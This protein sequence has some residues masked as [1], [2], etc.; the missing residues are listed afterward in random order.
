[1]TTKKKTE[2]EMLKLLR[3]RYGAEQGN[4][5]AYAFVEGV[6]ND[7]GFNASRTIDAMAMSLWPSRGLL[8]SAF[9]IKTAR[10]DWLRELRDPSKA[11]AF[12]RYV[13]FFYLVVSDE[14]IVALGELP[15][16]WGLMAPR[17]G[18]IGVVVEA[19]RLQGAQP[20]SRGML[21]ALLRQAGVAASRPPDEISEARLEGYHEGLDAGRQDQR[22]Q[23]E[24][25]SERNTEMLR[26]EREFDR[27]VG[28]DFTSLQGK[29]D[30]F[31][32]AVK[33]ALDGERD[34]EHLVSRIRRVGE[35][36]KV[37]HEQAARILSKYEEAD[38]GP[39]S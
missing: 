30:S 14:K 12:Q 34:L 17:G 36:S 5:P 19:P 33:A 29:P 22:S 9:E 38:D 31:Y 39:A 8:L 6:R 4:G 13:D 18:G 11:E 27:R 21:A 32:E 35:D 10:S 1:M 3:R 25:L 24:R 37:L 15:S 28:A 26:R 23:V 7:A 16:T 2:D 20:M